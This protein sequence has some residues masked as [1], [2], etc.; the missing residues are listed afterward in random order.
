MNQGRYRY[1][2]IHSF[3]EAER[4]QFFGRERETEELHRLLVSN[5]IVV[6]YGKSGTGKTSLLQ[7]GLFPTLHEHGW[8]PVKLH[9]NDLTR[10]ISRQV[11]E[12]FN[13]GEYLPLDT[14]DDL[15]LLEYCRRFD[16]TYRGKTLAPLLLLDQFEA[17][18]ACYGEK[19]EAFAQFIEQL[20]ELLSDPSPG[21]SDGL[22]VTARVV[23]SLRS[24]FLFLLDRIPPYLPSILRC[25]YELGPLNIDNAIKA[26]SSPAAQEGDFVSPPFSFNEKALK[27][28][29][30]GLSDR[31]ETG[32]NS[33]EVESYLL[34]LFCQQMERSLIR[35]GKAKGFEVTSE[36]LG[37]KKGID[38]ILD[39]FYGDAFALFEGVSKR[40]EGQRLAKQERLAALVAEEKR[41]VAER[42][43]D[44]KKKTEHQLSGEVKRAAVMAVEALLSQIRRDILYLD[45]KAAFEKL[46]L[47]VPLGLFQDSLGYESMEIA[48]FYHYSD[49]GGP[50]A[51][52][53]YDLAA[54][55]LG[56]DALKGSMDFMALATDK[57]KHLRARYLGDHMVFLEGGRFMMQSR[58]RGHFGRDVVAYEAEVS[59]FSLSKYETTVWQYHLFCVARGHDIS[60][61]ISSD[62]VT[63]EERS[64]QLSWGW[65]G[66]NPVVEVSWYDA[67]VYA[68]WLSE[69]WGRSPYYEIS[70]EKDSLN[71]NKFDDFKWTVTPNPKSNGFRL[72]T[73]LEWEYAAKGGLSRDTFA[74]SGSNDLDAVGWYDDNSSSR[75][76]GVGQKKA[77]GAGIYDMSG[78]VWEWCYDW[79]GDL[80]APTPLGAE[81][82]RRVYR[83]GSWNLHGQ[84]CPVSDRSASGPELR[85]YALG[86]R[87][88]RSSS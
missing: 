78:N 25:R 26:I 15:S 46:K 51:T 76:Q 58:G 47:A 66:D 30:E 49:R 68:N 18:F 84:F 53:A 41:V 16:Y 45:Y 59:D 3:T 29:L 9:L 88:A 21:F 62:G 63:L 22:R 6:L 14:P 48:Y 44:K 36:Y 42:A 37:G 23:I 7:A 75:T 64:F 56:K 27:I 61:R 77:N 20:N 12:Q 28:I 17:L 60:R 24:D 71:T 54:A 81:G 34:Q 4:G 19:P 10:S 52:E 82:N 35:E 72:P 5:P 83:G 85:Y 1:P 87:L 80:P 40:S 39:N 55:L 8:H 33:K 11:W 65:V 70:I 79:Y 31:S 50:L 67:V 74:Y 13:E 73:E 43:E 86:F 38:E 69:Q 32:E 57:A 2:G